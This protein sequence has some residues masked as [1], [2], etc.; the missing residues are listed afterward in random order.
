MQYLR[1][2]T[3]TTPALT[4]AQLSY[5]RWAQEYDGV[6]ESL[7][8][9]VDTSAM[10][11][12]YQSLVAD[13]N[14][15]TMSAWGGNDAGLLYVETPLDSCSLCNIST[16]PCSSTSCST[17][18]LGLGY[19]LEVG[20]FKATAPALPPRQL[21]DLLSSAWCRGPL[22]LHGLILATSGRSLV[23]AYRGR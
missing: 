9:L 7:S 18:G 1:N 15:T 19:R 17:T 4:T 16:G 23:D 12:Q 6:T 10:L 3:H 21:S 13:A 14:K 2:E 8:N 11:G 20:A 22:A 5:M